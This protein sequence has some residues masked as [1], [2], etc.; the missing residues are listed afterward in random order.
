MTKR[1]DPMAAW[2]AVVWHRERQETL[3][4]LLPMRVNL[5]QIVSQYDFQAV[6]AVK[7]VIYS[8]HYFRL[9]YPKHHHVSAK[10]MGA[11]ARG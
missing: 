5:N 1:A 8:L 3:A 4:K 2:S 9:L 7:A 6:K 10:T 11:H